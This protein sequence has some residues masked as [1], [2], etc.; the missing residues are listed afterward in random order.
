MITTLFFI[1]LISFQ[2]FYLTSDQVKH[3]NP[4]R[5]LAHILSHKRT[6]RMVSLGL[7]I[8]TMAGFVACLGW[9]SGICAGIVGLMGVGNLIVILNPFRYVSEKGVVAL[10]ALFLVLEFLI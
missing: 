8:V 3:S 6:Y 2:I 5:Y 4:S 7:M 10:Y 9:M 1:Q